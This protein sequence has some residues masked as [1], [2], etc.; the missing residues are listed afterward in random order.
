MM[1]TTVNRTI[2]FCFF[3]ASALL[4]FLALSNKTHTQPTP[5]YTYAIPKRPNVYKHPKQSSHKQ[6]RVRRNETGLPLHSEVFVQRNEPLKETTP[7]T[8]C[9]DRRDTKYTMEQNDT[10]IRQPSRSQQSEQHHYTEESPL[11]LRSDPKKL[12]HLFL[13][14]DEANTTVI[15]RVRLYSLHV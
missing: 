13:Q 10:T 3:R 9:I 11:L 1:S 15:L 6:L 12:K 5:I 14:S 2:F 4:F 8:S 7:T